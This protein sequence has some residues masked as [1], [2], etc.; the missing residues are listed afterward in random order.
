[1]IEDE[2]IQSNLTN[3][4]NPEFHNNY[5]PCRTF[6][7]DIKNIIHN[8][9]REIEEIHTA[10]EVVDERVDGGVGVAHDVTDQRYAGHHV[11]L[12][13]VVGDPE[14]EGGIEVTLILR[15]YIGFLK[16][17]RVDESGRVMLYFYVQ[18][19]CYLVR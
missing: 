15:I 13:H 11:A 8:A 18:E 2:H 17:L 3:P 5:F 7:V 12:L 9:N 1:M 14:W 10:H 6:D 16:W 4:I 19:K